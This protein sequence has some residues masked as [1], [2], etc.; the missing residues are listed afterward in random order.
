MVLQ[1]LVGVPL[2]M[3]H[4]ATRIGLVYAAGVV[5]GRLVGP[6]VNLL[7]EGQ[8]RSRGWYKPWLPGHLQAP[9]SGLSF[10]QI[11]HSHPDREVYSGA[12]RMIRN[13][14]T[15]RIP[16]VELPSSSHESLGTFL[17]PYGPVKLVDRAIESCLLLM[18][19]THETTASFYR[20][21]EQPRYG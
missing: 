9:G 18:G 19:A 13:R 6:M 12:E 20:A 3:V 8:R 11:S 10:R 16:A 7:R 14:T 1:L 15:E 17:G 21:K 2:E 4:G 5:A